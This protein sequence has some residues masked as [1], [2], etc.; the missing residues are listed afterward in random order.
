LT[1]AVLSGQPVNVWTEMK[2]WGYSDE[3]I[4]T[5]VSYD[6]SHTATLT[7]I[8]GLF[9]DTQISSALAGSLVSAN[10]GVTYAPALSVAVP[11]PQTWATM[12]VG[13]LA[14][15]GWTRRRRGAGQ[16]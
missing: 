10:G 6:F 4:P 1:F 2:A 8:Q 9:P 7:S 14:L 13:L 15:G 12:I 3:F 16:R 5:R 11:E